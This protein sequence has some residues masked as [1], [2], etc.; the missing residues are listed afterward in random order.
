MEMWKRRNNGQNRWECRRAEKSARRCS[1]WKAPREVFWCC[2][3]K[4]PRLKGTWRH[5]EGLFLWGGGTLSWTERHRHLADAT[6]YVASASKPPS[7]R[8][9]EVDFFFN[10]LCF[11][12]KPKMIFFCAVAWSKEEKDKEKCR[13]KTEENSSVV[14]PPEG[15]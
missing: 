12:K 11:A 5:F 13:R 7:D 8:H 4:P 2:K 6:C 14:S 3:K 10:F 9:L 15:F 1:S